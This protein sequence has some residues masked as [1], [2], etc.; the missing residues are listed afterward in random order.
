GVEAG[1]QALVVVGH[2]EDVEA[3]GQLVA[4]P[5]ATGEV[6]PGFVGGLERETGGGLVAARLQLGIAGGGQVQRP[7]GAAAVDV[8]GN[9][10][11]VVLAVAEGG[12]GVGIEIVL[13][14]ADVV[15]GIAFQDQAGFATGGAAGSQQQAG[16]EGAVCVHARS[17]CLGGRGERPA[18]DSVLGY[19]RSSR[20]AVFHSRSGLHAGNVMTTRFCWRCGTPSLCSSAEH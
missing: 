18:P 15:A 12:V 6:Q 11:V 9:A 8:Q 13:A 5:S 20:L 14:L 19:L 16:N 4:A 7:P 2:L 3:A 10:V 1:D 17:L